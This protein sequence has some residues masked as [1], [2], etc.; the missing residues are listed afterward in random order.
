MNRVKKVCWSARNLS[1]LQETELFRGLS[2]DRLLALLDW[3]E[4]DLY[5]T[6]N[7]GGSWSP[8][9]RQEGI[10]YVLDGGLTLTP[11]PAMDTLEAK[12]GD[13]PLLAKRLPGDLLGMQGLLDPQA[14][15]IY[16]TEIFPNSCILHLHTDKLDYRIGIASGQLGA[17]LQI[18]TVNL[19]RIQQLR[20]QELAERILLMSYKNL[21]GKLAAFLLAEAQRQGREAFHLDLTREGMAAW[22][23]V[24]RTTLCRELSALRE[25]G[26]LAYRLSDYHLLNLPALRKMATHR[27]RLGRPM[28]K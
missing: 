6:E 14:H 15:W 4:A 5:Q 22:L 25:E 18:F 24:S 26:I 7:R 1:R 11:P 27:G 10:W 19:L 21:R 8:G 9:F 17:A 28:V 20:A 13:L 16:Q 12:R 3:L 23:Q 2:E